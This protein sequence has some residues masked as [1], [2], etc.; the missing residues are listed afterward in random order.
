MLMTTDK[1]NKNENFNLL[2][3]CESIL[4][5]KGLE[6]EELLVRTFAVLSALVK[7]KPEVFIDRLFVR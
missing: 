6:R 1:K 7:N 5:N 2:G 4:I 3:T